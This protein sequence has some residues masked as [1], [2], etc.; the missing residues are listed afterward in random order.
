MIFRLLVLLLC[1]FCAGCFKTKEKRTFT[2]AR[3]A[4]WEGVNL[5]GTEKKIQ[6][7][8]NDLIFEISRIENAEFIVKSV[9]YPGSIIP[10]LEDPSIAA[11]LSVLEPTPLTLKNYAFSDPFFTFGPV[12]V[13]TS[14]KPITSFD[15]L[16]EKIVGFERG[17]YGA[18]LNDT[19]HAVFRPY[20]QMTYAV[21]DL[22]NGN[23]DV[24]ILDSIYAYQL[25]SGIYAGKIIIIPLKLPVIQFRA[26]VKK[27]PN[28]E[29]ILLFN[30]GLK[31]IKESGVYEKMLRYWEVFVPN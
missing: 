10:L 29:F 6:G 30:E 15:E 2:I 5:H 26:V 13:T 20:D 22:V 11:V 19:L 16:Q 9:E 7:F 27:G 28:E 1:L 18:Y 25:A 3:K 8:T 31:N 14:A 21:E 24:L 4:T 23:I 12:L 17:L